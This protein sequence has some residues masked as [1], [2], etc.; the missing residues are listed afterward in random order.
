M[1]CRTAVRNTPSAAMTT[2]AAD[3][4]RKP[5]RPIAQPEAGPANP[6]ASSET[7]SA[8]LISPRDQPKSSSNGSIRIPGADRTPAEASSNKKPAATITHA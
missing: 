5:Q 3:V 4:A 1:F 7:A 2:N 6:S 8:Q